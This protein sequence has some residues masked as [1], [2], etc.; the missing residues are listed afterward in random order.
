MESGLIDVSWLDVGVSLGLIVICIGIV[1]SMR[2][3][4]EKDLIVG[5]VRTIIQLAITG[6][7]LVFVFNVNSIL[8]VIAILLIMGVIAAYT[9]RGRVKQPFPNAIPVL[10]FSITLGSLFTLGFVTILTMSDPAALTARYLIPLGGMAIG[11]T[12]NGMSLAAERFRSDLESRKD[13]IEL[14]LSLGATFDRAVAEFKKS[15][16]VAAMIPTLNSMMIV[17]LIQIPG[18]MTG[19][20]LSG[21]DPLIAARYQIIIMFMIVGGKTVAMALGL[22]L[23]AKQYFTKDHQMRMELL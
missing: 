22:N 16:F 7:F 21:E 3:G 4:M 11:N 12:L 20:I 9:A 17:G 6:Y 18:I 5:T 15:A 10:Y 1:A 8:F 2:W 23:M 19:Q 14:L 13:K